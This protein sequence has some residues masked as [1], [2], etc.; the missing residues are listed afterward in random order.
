MLLNWQTDEGENQAVQQKNDELP[1]GVS[2]QPG[3]RRDHVGH[4]AR[5]VQAGGNHREHTREGELSRQTE[6]SP[7]VV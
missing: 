7:Q 2:L 5:Q 6:P 4:P 3:L 1:K